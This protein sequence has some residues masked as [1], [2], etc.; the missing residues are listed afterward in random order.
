MASI[1]QTSISIPIIGSDHARRRCAS[2]ECTRLETLSVVRLFS[3]SL[4][5]TLSLSRG[6]VHGP[7]CVED[8][9]FMTLFR[10]L[11]P[12]LCLGEATHSTEPGSTGLVRQPIVPIEGIELTSFTRA[13]HKQV[14]NQQVVYLVTSASLT[15]RTNARDKRPRLHVRFLPQHKG[16]IESLGRLWG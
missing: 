9:F 10:V 16:K 2:I 1:L 13:I 8:V 6:P 15:K 11:D 4:T 7:A 5:G 14:L 12:L 3:Q